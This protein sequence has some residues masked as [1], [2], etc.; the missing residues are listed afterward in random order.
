M[1]E[2]EQ[3]QDSLERSLL[4]PDFEGRL[5]ADKKS[6]DITADLDEYLQGT[7]P[8]NVRYAAFLDFIRIIEVRDALH[9]AFFNVENPSDESGTKTERKSNLRMAEF[10]KELVKERIDNAKSRWSGY[11]TAWREI[12]NFYLDLEIAYSIENDFTTDEYP[13]G[14]GPFAIFSYVRSY[15]NSNDRREGKTLQEFTESH[16]DTVIFEPATIEHLDS[17]I[18]GLSSR[19]L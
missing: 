11:D 18:G 1:V 6:E 9:Q 8:G 17:F 15:L 16:D 14:E 3:D 2:I 13:Y 10:R 5:L 19:D 12:D 4:H 7:E